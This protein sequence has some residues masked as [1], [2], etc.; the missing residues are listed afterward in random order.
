MRDAFTRG[1]TPTVL[2][3]CLAIFAPGSVAQPTSNR[4]HTAANVDAVLIGFK[5][6]RESVHPPIASRGLPPPRENPSRTTP[7]PPRTLC[8]AENALKSISLS[9]ATQPC[10]VHRA[11]SLGRSCSAHCANLPLPRHSRRQIL[12]ARFPQSQPTPPPRKQSVRH[13]LRWC[14]H[15]PIVEPCPEPHSSASALAKF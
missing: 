5:K 1:S 8:G 12:R 3:S 15:P 7:G 4:S 10:S 9:R 6:R 13:R 11:N 2:I 14:F